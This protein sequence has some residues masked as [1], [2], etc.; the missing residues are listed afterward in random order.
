MV[1]DNLK[2][3]KA[4]LRKRL[5]EQ[6]AKID[7]I[8]RDRAGRAIVSQLVELPF[9]QKAKVIAAY[10]ATPHE[11]DPSPLTTAATLAGKI[12]AYP[13]A[14]SGGEMSFHPLDDNAETEQ[15]PGGIEQPTA[16]APLINPEQIDVILVPLLACDDRGYR[17]GYGGGFYDRYLQRTPAKRVGIG[18]AQQRREQLPAETHDERLDCFVSEAG[19]VLF[20]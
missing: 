6:R 1:V 3:E 4:A 16:A 9:W 12:V 2:T 7:P 17:L 15:G 19:V 18:F 20:P 5:R 11:L 8:A 13:R 10:R 14:L